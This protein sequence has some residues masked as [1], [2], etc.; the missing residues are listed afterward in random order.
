MKEDIKKETWDMTEGDLCS[1]LTSAKLTGMS[2]RGLG[3]VKDRNT[4]QVSL[5]SDDLKILP[6]REYITCPQTQG[7]WSS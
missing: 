3:V 7:L 1:P 2:T 6:S 4:K 5:P